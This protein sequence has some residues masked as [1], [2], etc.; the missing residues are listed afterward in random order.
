MQSAVIAWVA[1][2]SLKLSL[3][4]PPDGM[5]TLLIVAVTP[6]AYFHLMLK[7]PNASLCSV[8]QMLCGG[9]VGRW[10]WWWGGS[11]LTRHFWIISPRLVMIVSPVIKISLSNL[12]IFPFVA[13]LR[14]A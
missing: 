1:S 9:W 6:L 13:S 14:D 3:I 7:A 4:L 8:T 12:R 11:A 10:W 2:P 5:M